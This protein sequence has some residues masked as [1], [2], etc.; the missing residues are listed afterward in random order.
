MKQILRV[1]L[2]VAEIVASVFA[3]D[4]GFSLIVDPST[5][6]RVAGIGL[7]F[8]AGAFWYYRIQVMKHRR[9]HEG[10]SPSEANVDSTLNKLEH[11]ARGTFR[12]R[13]RDTDW[14]GKRGN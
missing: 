5:E 11:F 2:F 8:L 10:G 6:L 1:A 13:M 14:P 7:L 3:A 12:G 4:V 9:E